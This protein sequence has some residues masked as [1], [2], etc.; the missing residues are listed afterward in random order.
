MIGRQ[1]MAPEDTS[2]S[3][4]TSCLKMVRLRVTVSFEVMQNGQITIGSITQDHVSFDFEKS[5]TDLDK[6]YSIP[7]IHFAIGEGREDSCMLDSISTNQYLSY[8]CQGDT[9]LLLYSIVSHSWRCLNLTRMASK[10]D[11]RLLQKD[12]LH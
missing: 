12:R 9:R 11:I 7:Y 2:H 6:V 5:M 3:A 10:P 1:R 8:S 4:L